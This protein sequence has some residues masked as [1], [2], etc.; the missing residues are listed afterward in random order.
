M[1]QLHD[2]FLIG[3]KKNGYRNR[4]HHVEVEHDQEVAPHIV[5]KWWSRSEILSLCNTHDKSV[6]WK[7]GDCESWGFI[8]AHSGWK[9][10]GDD[11]AN[12]ERWDCYVKDNDAAKC[13]AQGI[14]HPVNVFENAER[15]NELHRKE[16]NAKAVNVRD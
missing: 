13:V 11:H 5:E 10:Q 4:I 8:D 1:A 16:L 6:D 14:E 9:V 15:L 12:E 7:C 3:L 2:C